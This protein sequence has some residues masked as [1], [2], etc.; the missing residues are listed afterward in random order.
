MD[1]LIDNGPPPACPAN[2]NLAAYVL[3][4]ASKDP[5][6]AALE[7]LAN[8]TLLFVRFLADRQST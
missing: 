1:S 3:G 8:L 6:A 7:L 4:N 2:F 5:D